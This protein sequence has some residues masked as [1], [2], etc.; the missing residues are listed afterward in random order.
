M[1]VLQNKLGYSKRQILSW[2]IVISLISLG[3]KLYLVDFS[4][5]P[6]EDTFGYT[7]RAF[8]HNNGDFTEPARKTLGWSL[9]I[10]PFFKLVDSDHFIDYTNVVS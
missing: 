10:S 5:L 1:H 3:L 6:P 9:V 2:L 7:L 8:S 4:T